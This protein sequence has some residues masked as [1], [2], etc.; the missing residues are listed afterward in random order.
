MLSKDKEYKNLLKYFYIVIPAG[1]MGTRLWPLSRANM[2]KFLHD[3]T[4]SGNSLLKET[5]YR[6]K[7]VT[8]NDILLIIGHAHKNAVCS[9]LPD[10]KTENLILENE[11]KDSGAAIGLASALFYKRNPKIIMGSFAADHVI[12]SN[13]LFRKSIKEALL[14]ASKGYIVT[15]GIK[16]TH[17]STEFGHIRIGQS[18]KIQ[19]AKN[20]KSVI[21]FIE[22]PSKY[23][24]K[25]YYQSGNFH[26]NAGMF[27]APVEIIL[28]H[29]QHNQPNLY[30]GLKEIAN[31][32]HL[33]Q[34]YKIFSKIWKNLPKIAIDYAVIEPAA[35]AGDVA[36]IPGE[37]KWD[38][39]GDFSA[40]GRLHSSNKK[41]ENKKLTIMRGK[42]TR[43]LSENKSKKIIISNTERL[44]VL[45]GINN[46]V[47][48]DTPDVLLVTNLSDA[49]KVKQ[50]VNKLKLNGDIDVL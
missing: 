12:S 41:I 17:P 15:I 34:K 47:I 5:Y 37:F 39:V 50:T 27:I 29:L 42:K 1:G 48:V 32:W 16:P 23:F 46:A 40:I 6:L 24:A 14:T 19:G 3:L 35:K 10:I 21:Q 49:N 13:I 36:M 2:P 18:L 44:I 45:I 43:I 33:P 31:S 22:K 4:G 7:P 30:F 26:W 11:P 8:N 28:K 20:A 38:D 9:Q 25:K